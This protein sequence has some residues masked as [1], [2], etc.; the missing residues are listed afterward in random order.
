M[1]QERYSAVAIVLHWVIAL[2]ILVQIV[3][4]LVMMHLQMPI[5]LKFELYQLHKSV[6]ITLLIAV[7]L[8]IVWRLTHR[9]PALPA[10][11]P[12]LERLAADTT[13]LT[14]YLFLLGL[15]LTGWALVS[16]SPLNIPTVLY[17][18]LPWP[19][20]PVLAA[21][22]DKRDADAVITFIH[23]RLGFVLI[24]LIALHVAAALRHHFLL[25]DN[26][27]QRMLPTLTR[28]QA[29]LK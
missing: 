12:K 19:N 3:M 27:L 29:G 6:G 10:A 16:V 8:R 26:I 28:K 2:G 1:M 5:M 23:S 22:P 11:L 14:L 21:L 9:P 13:H 25:R 7:L 24:G 4:G 15:P 17:G 20:M 18:L